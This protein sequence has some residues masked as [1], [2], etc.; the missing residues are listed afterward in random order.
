MSKIL[1]KALV[2][3]LII[4]EKFIYFILYYKTFPYRWKMK[5]MFLM[6]FSLLYFP[7][8]NLNYKN[9]FLFFRGTQK[10]LHKFLKI[11]NF[12][13][14]ALIFSFL[15]LSFFFLDKFEKL[16]AYIMEIPCK[17]KKISTFFLFPSHN[18]EFDKNDTETD[19]I[20]KL[21][22]QLTTEEGS[23]ELR[24]ILDNGLSQQTNMIF[25]VFKIEQ[26][27]RMYELLDM[28]GIPEL[29]PFGNCTTQL[30]EFTCHELKLGDSM[31][32]VY[33]DVTLNDITATAS[34][35]FFTDTSCE[36]EQKDTT[37]DVLFPCICFVYDRSHRN[38]LFCGVLLDN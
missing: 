3:K 7:Q 5:N 27:L 16:D 25:P 29:T 31:H 36:R 28:L 19:R 8:F 15:I 24:E 17:Q 10:T 6:F 37:V 9:N 1:A 32:R 13:L 4:N 2:S 11:F 14:F 30:Y 34:N 38:I 22:E 23:Q 26:D 35:I 21:I 12:Y 18:L 20:I 33:I